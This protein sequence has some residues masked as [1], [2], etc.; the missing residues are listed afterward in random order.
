MTCK[1]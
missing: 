1:S